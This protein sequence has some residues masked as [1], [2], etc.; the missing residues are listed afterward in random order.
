MWPTWPPVL[1]LSTQVLQKK[2]SI[3]DIKTIDDLPGLPLTDKAD[4]AGA[5]DEFLCVPPE[6]VVDF[7]LTS[8]TTGA[9][10]PLQQTAADLQRLAFNEEISFRGAGIASGDRV[11]IAVA[12]DRCFMAG[13]AYFLGLLRI[14]AL[15][16]RGGSGSLPVLAELARRYRPTAII[17]VPTL[18]LRLAERLAGSGNDPTAMGVKRLICIGEPVRDRGL[19]LS[20][21][22]DRLANLWQ[23]SLYG[24]Y[25]STEMATSFSDCCAGRGGHVPAELVAVEILDDKGRPLPAGE[26]GE[27]VATP[28][29]V[30]G[31]PL[32]RFRTAISPFFMKIRALAGAERRALGRFWEGFPRCSRFAA[33]LFSP[34]RFF[35]FLRKWKKSEAITWRFSMNSI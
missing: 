24:T 9:P 15:A 16:I 34:N 30:T 25:A 1:L 4:L 7:C 32:L 29:Q 12:L 23:A 27:V 35:P 19:A 14:G 26:A 8:G 31:M 11:L 13:L 10:V 33:R 20:A 2:K 18:L 22:G 28:F 21:L 6:Q 3:S 17:G 5:A